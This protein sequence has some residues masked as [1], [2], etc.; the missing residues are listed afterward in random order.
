MKLVVNWGSVCGVVA[1]FLASCAD[2]PQYSNVPEIIFDNIIFKDIADP[3]AVDSLIVTVRFKDGDGDI[4]L[5]ASE[6]SPPYNDKFYFRLEGL[7]A[8]PTAVPPSASDGTYITYKTNR[9]IAKFDSLPD[10]VKPYNCVNW[11]IKTVNQK[12]DTFYFQLNPNHYNFFVDF[13]IKSNDGTYNKFNWLEQ[14]AYPNCGVTSFDQRFP[15]LSKDLSQKTPLDGSIRN[16]MQSAGFL[17]LFSIKT[18]MLKITIQDR[19]L[20]KS[21]TVTTGDFKLLDIRKGG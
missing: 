5:E 9:T 7:R 21:N 12:L 13:Y 6:L 8:V 16:S 19:A 14:F 18:L 11:E 20:N 1:I 10:F 17:P 3:S 15:I 2:P 4:G